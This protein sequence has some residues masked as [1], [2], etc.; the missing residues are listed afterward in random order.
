MTS[1][2][3]SDR[4]DNLVSKNNNY[5]SKSY[6]SISD[7]NHNNN[8]NQS[9]NTNLLNNIFKSLNLDDNKASSNKVIQSENSINYCRNNFQFTDSGT[10]LLFISLYLNFNRITFNWKNLVTC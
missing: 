1:I 9:I 3:D 7:N 4:F 6:R 5:N 10:K 2:I 8:N